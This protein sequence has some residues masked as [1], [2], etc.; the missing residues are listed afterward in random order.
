MRNFPFIPD[1]SN[2]YQTPSQGYLT[3]ECPLCE[4]PDSK[5]CSYNTKKIHL[6]MTVFFSEGYSQ[7]PMSFNFLFYYY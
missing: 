1:L 6:A 4:D 7:K 2:V 3:L 5:M